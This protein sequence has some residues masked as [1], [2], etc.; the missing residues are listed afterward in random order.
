MAHKLKYK[1][2]NFTTNAQNKAKSIGAARPFNNFQF[3]SGMT[4]DTD[5]QEYEINDLYSREDESSNDGSA[6][7]GDVIEI[8]S[9][10]NVST[11]GYDEPSYSGEEMYTEVLQI[12]DECAICKK[13][14]ASHLSRHS[15]VI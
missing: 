3:K 9:E 7:N 14:S 13:V 11:G 5:K 12:Q 10:D 2:K 8:E 1:N 15:Q 4:T 6:D